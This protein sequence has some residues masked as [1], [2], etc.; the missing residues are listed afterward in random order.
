MT[1]CGG[2][3][4]FFAAPSWQ[5]SALPT[6]SANRGV[7]DVSAH[8]DGYDVGYGTS[9]A[10]PLWASLFARVNQT[11]STSWEAASG[12]QSW[13]LVNNAVKMQAVATVTAMWRSNDTHLDLF[14]TGDDR[15]WSTSWEAAV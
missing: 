13:F 9:A 10:S 2:Y 1:S 5:T 15:V 14:A 7:P 8:A 3:S 4:S 12:W 6:G 11:W